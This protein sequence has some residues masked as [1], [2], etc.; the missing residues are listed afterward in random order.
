M[1]KLVKYTLICFFLL[2]NKQQIQ[3]Q[4]KFGL[5]FI[6]YSRV[7]NPDFS[8]KFVADG[9]TTYVEFGGLI[10]D[11]YEAGL[12]ISPNVFTKTSLGVN[13][14]VGF[15]INLSFMPYLRYYF[16]ELRDLRPYV[17]GGLGYNYNLTGAINIDAPGSN[18]ETL[19]YSGS[20]FGAR[21]GGGLRFFRFLDISVI[22]YYAGWVTPSIGSLYLLNNLLGNNSKFKDRYHIH[23]FEFQFAFVF[24]GNLK[25]DEQKKKK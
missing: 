1:N 20:S 19:F 16:L 21:I 4:F 11:H 9:W 24:G 6:G 3:A 10:K 7:V 2:L 14:G 17:I 8:N 22:Y 15:L 13:S 5:G 25:T 23:V 12:R 18:L